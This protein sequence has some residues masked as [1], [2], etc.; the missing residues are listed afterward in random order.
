ME[1][2]EKL[3]DAEIRSMASSAGGREFLLWLLSLCNLYADTFTGNSQ[4]YYLEGKR[5]VGLDILARLEEV[6]KTIYP[7]ML[8]EKN[9][10]E[11]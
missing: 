1:F 9:K 2:D 5:A 3:I 8:L 10:L 4:T 11:D 7:L 6:E